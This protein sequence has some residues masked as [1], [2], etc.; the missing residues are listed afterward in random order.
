MKYSGKGIRV[1]ILDTGIAAHPD[2]DNRII[3][4]EDFV[5]KKIYPYDDNGH[6][7]HVGDT[8]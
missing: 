1:A 5:N 6:G 7:T 4:F 8:N 3:V 2:F